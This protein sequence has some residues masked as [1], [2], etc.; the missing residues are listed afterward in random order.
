MLTGATEAK[1]SRPPVNQKSN[2]VLGKEN[3]AC[4]GMMLIGCHTLSYKSTQE[5]L[6]DEFVGIPVIFGYWEA[7][8]PGGASQQ[9]SH[10]RSILNAPKRTKPSFFEDPEAHFATVG[11]A[12]KCLSEI[13]GSIS[14]RTRKRRIAALYDYTLYVPEYIWPSRRWMHAYGMS[15]IA[16]AN[17]SLAE[18]VTLRTCPVPGRKNP[19]V[20][21]GENDRF[22]V[23]CSKPKASISGAL[24]WR[25]LS[26][27]SGFVQVDG[28]LAYA[29]DQI[30]SN[31]QSLKK[32]EPKIL[33]V[34]KSGTRAVIDVDAPEMMKNAIKGGPQYGYSCVRD[35]T[36][37]RY[38]LSVL[39]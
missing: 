6:V 34:D 9:N 23:D 19:F 32:P 33:E 27:V 29:L 31:T 30:F 21:S 2:P 35:G 38:T 16:R 7:K 3:H 15:I 18:G 17:K 26:S 10:I 39:A 22:I 5:V 14:K 4:L 37:T 8:A 1:I 20:Y 13:I 25:V 12:E 28:L 24:E 11:G 36:G